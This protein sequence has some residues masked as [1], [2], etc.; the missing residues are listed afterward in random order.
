MTKSQSDLPT[1]Q[2]NSEILITLI[3]YPKLTARNTLYINNN[4]DNVE[5]TG[6]V[7]LMDSTQSINLA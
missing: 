6:M 2:K 4:T 7:S 5:D 1:I 3:N